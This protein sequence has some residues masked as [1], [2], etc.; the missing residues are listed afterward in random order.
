MRPVPDP[1]VLTTQMADK[2]EAMLRNLIKTEIEHRDDLVGAEFKLVDQQF[3]DL[4]ERTAEQK[5]DTKDALD[6][7]LAA[8]KEA[9]RE[10]TIS[11]EKSIT[12]S[13]T[14]TA[15]RIRAVEILLGS[16]TTGIDDKVGDLKDRIVAIENRGVGLRE[17][18]GTAHDTSAAL[19]ARV[20]IVISALVLIV[21]IAAIIYSAVKP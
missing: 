3:T 21:S 18:A 7:A 2:M 6:A 11:S 1:T 12:K 17:A 4:K 14:G 15:E 20:A 16:A 13:E 10:S 8:Q 9:A 5:R 19:M